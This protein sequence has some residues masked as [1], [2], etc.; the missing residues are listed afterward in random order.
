MDPVAWADLFSLTLSPWEL[1]VR[2]SVMYG[3]LFLVFRFVMRRDVSGIGIAD[4]L[5]LVIIADASQNAF[6]GEYRSIADGMLLV[7]VLVGWNYLIDWLNYRVAWVRRFAEPPPLLLVRDGQLIRRNMR[8]ERITE[9][10]L[11]AKLREQGVSSLKSVK[12]M[13]LESDGQFS[14]V[15]HSG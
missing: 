8:I 15:K 12:R 3:F 9:K 7:S 13:Y 1:I 6:S 10:E 14:V 11:R 5:V 4:I 2:G